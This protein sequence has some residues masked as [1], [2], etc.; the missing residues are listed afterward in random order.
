PGSPLCPGALAC[1]R[2]GR[3][4]CPVGGPRCGPCLHPLVETS[5]GRCVVRRRLAPAPSPPRKG[6]S[7]DPELD[8]EIDFLSAV[9]SE[10]RTISKDQNLPD[11]EPSPAAPTELPQSPSVAPP[12]RAA[13]T[14]SDLVG[15]PIT[16]G[17][18][19]NHQV[20][21]VMSAVLVVAGSVALALAGAC[22][23]RLGTRGWPTAPRCST[24]STRSSRCSPWR[25]TGMSPKFLTLERRQSR[26]TRMEISPCTS[27]Q[28]W[29]PRARWR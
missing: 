26:R 21:V 17:H 5:R 19:S 6:L 10:Q 11:R 4:F 25:N 22:W 23:F 27:V 1:A 18:A 2:L 29:R 3:Q 13:N 7:R 20:F 14:T 28:A 9:I 15:E 8:E 12:T 24:T 16:L